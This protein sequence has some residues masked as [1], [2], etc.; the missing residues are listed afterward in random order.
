MKNPEFVISKIER[1]EGI[2]KNIKVK[3]TRPNFSQEE[4]KNYLESIEDQLQDV[5]SMI[6]REVKSF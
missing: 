5:K 1:I 6:N 4:F 2:I 3:S